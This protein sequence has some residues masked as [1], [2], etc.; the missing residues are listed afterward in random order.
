MSHP[1]VLCLRAIHSDFREV[2]LLIFGQLAV[3]AVPVYHLRFVDFPGIPVDNL[4]CR[5]HIE[6][7]ELEG[8]Y[9]VRIP[10]LVFQVVK[11]LGIRLGISPPGSNNTAGVKSERLG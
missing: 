5:R 11:V 2:G 6:R 7:K 4:R 3:Q 9:S 1:V 10:A 8:F